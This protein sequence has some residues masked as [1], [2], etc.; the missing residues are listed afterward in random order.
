MKNMM[1]PVRSFSMLSSVPKKWNMSFPRNCLLALV[2]LLSQAA[3]AQWRVGASGGGDYNWFTINKQYMNNYHYDG[4]WGW[5][6]AVFG[7]YN[8]KDWL[9]LRFELEASERNHRVYRDGMASGTNYIN[10][11]T[12]LQLP[13]MAQFSFGGQK[14]RGFMHAGV[15][16][17]Y[18]LAGLQKGKYQDPLSRRTYNFKAKYRFQE[19]KDQRWDFGIAG[20]VGIEYRFV[21]HWVM[22]VEGR[23]YYSF[24]STVKPYM[25]H[26]RDYRYNTTVGMNLGFAYIF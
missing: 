13:V 23:C 10:H 1:L 15:Y 14:V 11:N 20:G 12:Y 22:H 3:M 7:Q 2:V 9:G 19:E 8:F 18:W 26:V 5:N 16:A 17:G 4:A 24:I 25:E 21:E 6:A